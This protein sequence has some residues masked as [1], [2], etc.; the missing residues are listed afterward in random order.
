MTINVQYHFTINLK[1]GYL[2][3][4]EIKVFKLIKKKILQKEIAIKLNISQ[5]A[6][7]DFYGNAKLKIKLAK[8]AL[9]LLEGCFK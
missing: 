3:D 5:A 7:S 6:V 9:K 1:R 8:E 4:K 2:T